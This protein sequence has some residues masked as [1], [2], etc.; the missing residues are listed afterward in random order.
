M[1]S[2]R[3]VPGLVIAVLVT[4]ALLSVAVT[5]VGLRRDPGPEVTRAPDPPTAGERLPE[6]EAATVLA[7][8]DADRAAA[9]AA[10]D[11]HGL[12]SLY[13]A[14]SVAG[15]RDA[16]M[17]RRWRDRGLVVDGLRTQVLSLHEVRRTADR[18]VLA[19]TDRVVGATVRG[20]TARRLPTDAASTY[21]LTLRR[22]GDRWL[23]ASVR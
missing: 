7:A 21:T 5:L 16:A 22:V 19:V 23:V 3:A 8:W 6:L 12:R 2:H 10:G 13:V 4:V 15:E 18:W 14:G 20:V 11:V 9:W 17:L 1:T